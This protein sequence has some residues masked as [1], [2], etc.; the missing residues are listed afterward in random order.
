MRAL[1]AV[2]FLFSSAA[3]AQHSTP[4]P[5][6]PPPPPVTSPTTLPS[7]PAAL[8]VPMPLGPPP[9]TIDLYVRPD[10]FHSNPPP[11]PGYAPPVFFPGYGYGYGY[12]YGYGPY[13]SYL[14][15]AGPPAPPRVG[16]L[17]F[18]THP[19]TAQVFVDG[20]YTGIVQDYGMDGRPL[21]LAV[22]QH[23]VEL[24]AAGYMPVSFNINISS[25]RPSRFRGDLQRSS[26]L[27]P[28]A[29]T[30]PSTYYV[31]P[32]CYAGNRP[33]VRALPKGCRLRDMRTVTVPHVAVRR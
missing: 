24:K 14:P 32:N 10:N 6:I 29:A 25:D 26:A 31:I 23:S 22:G 18:E 2:V 28:P 13:S 20:N 27:P 1:L 19:E 30:T 9:G 4:P 17:R 8:T 3:H 21:E 7:A 15:L 16:N 5:R 11:R 33:P 12:E